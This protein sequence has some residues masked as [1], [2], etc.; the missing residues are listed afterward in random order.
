MPSDIGAPDDGYILP[1]LVYHEHIVPASQEDARKSGRLFADPAQTLNDQRKARRGT[2]ESRVAIAARIANETDGP[3]IV[4]CDLND[5]SAALTK[6]IPG[7]VEVTGSMADEDKEAAI[8][9]FLSRESRVAVSK[10]SLLGFGL[11]MQF[12]R[13]QVFCG[14][15]HSFEQLYQ[16]VRRSWRYGVEGEVNVHLVSSELEGAVLENVKRKMADAEELSNE[17]RK[18]VSEYVRD[19]V[20]SLTRQTIEYNP[21][22]K[23]SWPA[24]LREERVS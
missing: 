18:Y 10:C 1:P 19:S 11:N 5:E 14:V 17:T 4:W 24:W 12:A 3:A 21:T 20:T 23:F 6:A 22:K 13:T 2:L 15:S 8:A 9:R 16:G 7:A